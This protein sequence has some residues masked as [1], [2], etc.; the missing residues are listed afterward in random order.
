MV[1]A[2]TSEVDDLVKDVG[3]ISRKRLVNQNLTDLLSGIGG[4]LK[5]N[6]AQ[7]LNHHASRTTAGCIVEIGSYRGRSA[8]ALAKDAT[9]PVYC[10]DPHPT[11]VD[12]MGGS[13]GSKDKRIFI[14]NIFKV[15]L[16]ERISIIN[17]KSD[18][19]A[20]GWTE[21]IGMLWIDGDHSFE[22]TTRDIV[23]W[24]PHLVGNGI[25]AIHDKSYV[26]VKRALQL[27]EED[28]MFE[29]IQSLGGIRAYRKQVGTP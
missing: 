18:Q 19:A 24:T 5:L 21:K 28:F 14:E 26:E 7:W 12:G 25:V 29:R 3:N 1:D 4:W 23:N 16:H 6:E 27:L 11:Y 17:L 9:V 2:W 15:G 8:I 13:F 22:Q 20:A 10:I